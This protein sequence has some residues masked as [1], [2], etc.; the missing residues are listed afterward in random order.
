MQRFS[1]DQDASLLYANRVPEQADDAEL[2]TD[3][4]AGDLAAWS[5]MYGRYADSLHDFCHSTLRDRVAAAQ[6]LHQ[7]FVVAA[8]RIG[9]LRDPATLRPWLYGLCLEQALRLARR[10]WPGAAGS[11]VAGPTNPAT[12][13]AAATE[14]YRPAWIAAGRLTPRDRAVLDLAVRH[15][16]DGDALGLA[17]GTGTDHA[18]ARLARVRRRLRR[19]LPAGTE[20]DALLPAVPA[21]PAPAGLRE[22]VLADVEA[23]TVRRLTELHA[24]GDA[25]TGMF[26]GVTGVDDLERRRRRRLAAATW[27]GAAGLL[28]A[29]LLF[30]TGGEQHRAAVGRPLPDPLV[31]QTT[32]TGGSQDRPAG[33]A[34]IGTTPTGRSTSTP[35]GQPS[36][37]TGSSPAPP[38]GEPSQRGTR[39]G[40]PSQP[41][42]R[43][44]VISE[45]H[46]DRAELSNGPGSCSSTLVSA[47][48]VAGSP[49]TVMLHWLFV[50][51]ASALS[52]T[53]TVRM[54][55][56]G[57]RYWASVGPVG[58]SG[59]GEGRLKRADGG[60]LLW[61]VT[62]TDDRGRQAS[63]ATSVLPVRE[64]ACQAQGVPATRPGAHAIVG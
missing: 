49:V 9:Q 7:T 30:A 61:W 36:G 60:E 19:S 12:P 20:P 28:I 8:G 64:V 23:A 16:L 15:H 44:P 34:S 32:T 31:V 42:G 29:G 47:R 45:L 39:P 22:P 21:L 55:P 24:A 17:F 56:D 41:P 59:N 54:R 4:V 57:D 52:G 1:P 51:P 48:V 53:V 63:S 27:W 5:E 40:P 25:A 2:A 26:G 3:A 33:P 62:A 6:A 58:A 13:V 43:P 50:A 14:P 35:A 11:T 38:T 46:S 18:V 10:R 37:R